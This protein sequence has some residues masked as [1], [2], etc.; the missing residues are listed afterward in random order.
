MK[1]KDLK[2]LIVEDLAT[3]VEIARRSLK[4]EKISFTDRVVDTAEDFEKALVE[5][6]P[7]LIISDYAMPRFDGMSALKITRSQPYYIPFIVLT[8]SMNE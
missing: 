7:D 6:K 2:I 5:Y 1:M 3:D 8:G 4:K